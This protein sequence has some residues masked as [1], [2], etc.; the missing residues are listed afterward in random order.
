MDM[1]RFQF[2]S[3]SGAVTFFYFTGYLWAVALGVVV[4][5]LMLLLSEGLVFRL[6]SNLLLSALWGGTAANAVA[7][8]G[9]APRGLLFYSFELSCGITAIFCIQSELFATTLQKLVTF[10][11]VI[12]KV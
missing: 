3:S 7:Q 6:T 9:A 2:A 12:C 1:K 5:V 11:S 4:L 8:M 10:F